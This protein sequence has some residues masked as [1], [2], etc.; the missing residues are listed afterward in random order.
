[1]VSPPAQELFLFPGLQL[2]K[3]I[4]ALMSAMICI[5]AEMHLNMKRGNGITLSR[6]SSFLSCMT[7][8]NE[9]EE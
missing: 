5:C 1:L 7:C 4:K 3:Y 6:A 9:E 2:Y 8:S